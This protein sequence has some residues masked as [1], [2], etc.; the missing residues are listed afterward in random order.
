VYLDSFSYYIPLIWNNIY[1]TFLTQYILQVM[2]WM[3]VLPC[4]VVYRYEVHP[5][6][7]YCLAI[8]KYTSCMKFL[9]IVMRFC[10]P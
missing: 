9:L 3:D 4:S 6:S 10:I 8:R 7:K 1:N 5:E 2:V